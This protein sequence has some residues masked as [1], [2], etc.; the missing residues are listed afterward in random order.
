MYRVDGITNT[1]SNLEFIVDVGNNE[2][3]FA[4]HTFRGLLYC[5]IYINRVLVAASVKCINRSWLLPA[6][7]LAAGGNFRFEGSFEDYVDTANFGKLIQLCYYP[8]DE[9]AETKAREAKEAGA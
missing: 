9:Y 7:Y 1:K 4:L 2:F 5:S 3:T 6:D 8:P